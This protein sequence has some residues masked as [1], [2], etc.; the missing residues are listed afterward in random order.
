MA[1]GAGAQWLV[2][3]VEA[4]LDAGASEPE[5]WPPQAVSTSVAQ[6]IALASSGLPGL[7]KRVM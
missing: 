1:Q 6:T 7:K 2:L 5:S 4:S 3:Q